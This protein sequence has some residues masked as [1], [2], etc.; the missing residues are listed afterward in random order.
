MSVSHLQS[1][2]SDEVLGQLQELVLKAILLGQRLPGIDRSVR[3]PD[4]PFVLQKSTVTL[5][6]E[7]LANSVSIAEI[8]VPVRN[9]SQEALLEEAREQGDIAYLRFQPPGIEDNVVRL[10]L[11]AKVCPHDSSQPVL[12]LSG[13]QVTFQKV[14]GNW[15]VVNEPVLFFN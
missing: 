4:L 5:I 14:S 13:I 3:F 9:L 1:T 7:N 15:Q 12:G 2:V 6:D 8:S 10:T 11:E